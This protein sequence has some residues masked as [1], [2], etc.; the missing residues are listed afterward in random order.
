MNH[1]DAVRLMASE[2]YLLDELEPQLRENFED[3]MFGCHECAL[4]VKSGITLIQHSKVVLGIPEPVLMPKRNP[5]VVDGAET[6]LVWLVASGVCRSGPRSSAGGTGISESCH[7]A[8][9]GAGGQPT[10]I[11]AV[12][13]DQCADARRGAH[14]DQRAIGQGFLGIRGD[15]A[16][17]EIFFV[18][19]PFV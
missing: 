15:S 5:V 8:E 11:A 4:D 7:R 10:A 9:A 12:G 3:H 6:E 16:R 14:P 19:G 18:Y 13:H 17:Q 2:K 1:S